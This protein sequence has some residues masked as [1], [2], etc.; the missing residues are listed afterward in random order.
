MRMSCRL[1]IVV[2]IFESWFL[3]TVIAKRI[4]GHITLCGDS[5]SVNFIALFII[6]SCIVWS[7][8]YRT[9]TVF[10]DDR[11]T[12]IR[13]TTTEDKGGPSENLDNAWIIFLLIRNELCKMIILWIELPVVWVRS[14]N[15]DRCRVRCWWWQRLFLWYYQ[16]VPCN[17]ITHHIFIWK[18]HIGLISR[19]VSDKKEKLNKETIH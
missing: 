6:I 5:L 1:C 14:L 2:C 9:A 13:V 16:L 11:C 8:D 3:S 7:L 10:C 12:S 18:G 19:V 17:M 15:Y 4:R